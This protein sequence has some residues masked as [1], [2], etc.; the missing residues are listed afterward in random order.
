ME[1]RGH[2]VPDRVTSG[3]CVQL[4]A[5]RN[6]CDAST[7]AVVG[8][9]ELVATEQVPIGSAIQQDYEPLVAAGVA[10]SVVA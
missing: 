9:R 6:S 5:G 1:G 8:F 3:S 4:I 7:Q 10:I 2:E